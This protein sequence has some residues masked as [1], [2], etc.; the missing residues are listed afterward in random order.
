M[1]DDLFSYYPHARGDDPDTSHEAV[2]VN[3][4]AQ[5]LRVL[6]A[7]RDDDAMLDHTA[8]RLV[9]L[10]VSRFTHQRCSDLRA[11]NLIERTGERGRTPS[12][13]AGYLC[14]ITQAGHDYLDKHKPDLDDWLL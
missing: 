4:T 12:G 3:I 8:Y 2:P 7:Y 9:G 1:G 6:Y 10:G 5:A 11:A 14:R 13:K